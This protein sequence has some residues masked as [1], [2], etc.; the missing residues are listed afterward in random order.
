MGIFAITICPEFGWSPDEPPV[1]VFRDSSIVSVEAEFFVFPHQGYIG[2]AV[3]TNKNAAMKG[4][5]NFCGE[6]GVVCFYFRHIG[7]KTKGITDYLK[8]LS[9]GGEL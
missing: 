3:I 6:I 9:A 2:G 7:A 5:N 1:V 8:F 4:G